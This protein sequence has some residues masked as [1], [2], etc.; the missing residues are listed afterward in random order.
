MG[1]RL[2]RPSKRKAA[3]SA[4]GFFASMRMIAAVKAASEGLC[5]QYKIIQ[6]G[7]TL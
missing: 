7:P 4:E 6:R 5:G 1:F 3:D 2:A